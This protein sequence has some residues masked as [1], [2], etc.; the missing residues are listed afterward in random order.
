MKEFTDEILRS[1]YM[2]HKIRVKEYIGPQNRPGTS[3]GIIVYGGVDP[4]IPR[5]HTMYGSRDN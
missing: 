1:H 2:M 4:I 5:P 3:E